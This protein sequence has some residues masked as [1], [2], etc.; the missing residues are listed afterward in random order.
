ML[1]ATRNQRQRTQKIGNVA[2]LKLRVVVTDWADGLRPRYIRD[3]QAAFG[4]I[5]S[6]EDVMSA[7]SLAGD[8]TLGRDQSRETPLPDG[9]RSRLLRHSVE[10]CAHANGHEGY[11]VVTCHCG[12]RTADPR[13]TGQTS[14]KAR[15]HCCRVWRSARGGLLV[16]RLAPSDGDVERLVRNA[17][18][19][20]RSYRR[21]RTRLRR[22]CRSWCGRLPE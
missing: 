4:S 3:Q 15:Q 16:Y 1:R 21:P 9:T 2:A 6:D 17:V 18:F 22:Q 14:E 8:G 20:G 5:Y 19:A 11:R 13:P 7:V 12:S 10:G